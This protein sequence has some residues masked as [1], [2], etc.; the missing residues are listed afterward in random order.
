MQQK[1]SFGNFA[2]Q[3]NE[4]LY[5]IPTWNALLKGNNRKYHS[6]CDEIDRFSKK[7]WMK[8]KSSLENGKQ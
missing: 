5:Q 1:L 2:S 3:I 4:Q 7:D 6:Q 8:P